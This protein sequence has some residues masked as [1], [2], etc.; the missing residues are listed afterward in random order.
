MDCCGLSS[1]GLQNID[2]NE[3]TADNATVITSLSVS[4]INILS[5]INNLNSRFSNLNTYIGTSNSSLNIT[6]TTQINFNAGGMDLTNI[7]STGLNVYHTR[8]TEF[9]LNESGYYNVRERLDNLRHVYLDAYNPIIKYDAD[10]NT[11]IK[12][13]EQE[14]GSTFPEKNYPKRII[15]KDFLDNVPG[16]FNS[17]GLNLLDMNGNYN[18]ISSKFIQTGNSSLL[19]CSNK[20]M[21]DSA[22]AL[23]VYQYTTN[24]ILGFVTGTS[25]SWLNVADTLN[26]NISNLSTLSTNYTELKNNYSDVLS[27]ITTISGNA[28]NIANIANYY[29]GLQSSLAVTN[30]VVSGSGLILAFNLKE[31]RFDTN[32]PLVKTAPSNGTSFNILSLNYNNTL[33]VDQNNKLSINTSGF[34]TSPESDLGLRANAT[35]NTYVVLKNISEPMTC[36][37]SLNIVGNTTVNSKLNVVG[38]LKCNNIILGAMTCM[39]SLNIVGNTTENSKLNID[40]NTTINGILNVS[41]NSNLNN[42]N[43]SGFT[44]LSNNT[45]INGIL[46]VSGFTRLSNNT[47]LISSLNVSGFTTLSNNTTINGI[48]NVSGHSILSNNTTLISSLNVSG[49]A[50][51]SNNTTLRSSLNISGFTTLSNNTSIF[52]TLNVS[53]FTR[54]SNNTTVVSSLN[55]SGRTIIGSDI[56][57][58][59]DS[60]VEMYKNFHI[61]KNIPNMGDRAEIMVGLGTRTSYLSME[62]GYDINL[63][64]SIGNITLNSFNTGGNV[65]SLQ[66]P[67]VNVS[68]NLVVTGSIYSNNLSSQKPF[69][70]TCSSVCSIG[71]KN[72]F[73][74]DIDLTKYTKYITNVAGG[75]LRKFKWMSWLSSGAHNS[76]QYSLNYDIDYAYSIWLVPPSL[77]GLNVLAYGF[78]CT[79]YN[80]NRVTPNGT[81]L[82]AYNFN[83]LSFISVKNGNFQAIIIDYL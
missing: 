45:T 59:P 66:A 82:W 79:N 60:V 5:S 67:Q 20:M 40:G 52:G 63:Y 34:L 47:T 73:R 3:F 53:G 51:L 16:Y 42:L 56:Y 12:I 69:T 19:L 70:F 58:Y 74:Y 81:F 26:A 61:R 15:F 57:N 6:G 7:D 33:T 80:L 78:P 77:N 49:F 46:N 2:A 64:N 71:G 13:N 37:S 8:V 43:V 21:V 50:T 22:G 68:K 38:D 39:S 4:G 35:G 10:N 25:G 41:G 36:M 83:T 44:T 32:Y 28:A 76:G 1:T 9:P 72:Y 18:N 75:T 14:V 24:T 65:I 29:S 11:V 55:I 17:S 54:L 27:Q 23:N 30:G 48:L 62:E 31:N